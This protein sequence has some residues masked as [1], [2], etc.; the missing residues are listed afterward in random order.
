MEY[1]INIVAALDP[2]KIAT[3]LAEAMAKREGMTVAE[4]KVKHEVAV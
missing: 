2:A 3:A 4:M 1:K